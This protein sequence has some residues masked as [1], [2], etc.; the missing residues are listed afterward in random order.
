MEVRARGTRVGAHHDLEG[1]VDQVLGHRL[2]EQVAHA[3]DEDA[4]GLAPAER[5]GQQIGV[6]RDGEAVPVAGIAHRVAL[7]QSRPPV[8]DKP[9]LALFACPQM[10]TSSERTNYRKS[11]DQ[12]LRL[13]QVLDCDVKLIVR[14]KRAW[15][16]ST[17]RVQS[18]PWKAAE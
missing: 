14:A 13:L 6:E 10:E 18:S 1:P 15:P 12:M 4:P 7:T 8:Q 16:T 5:E 11:V 9:K 17:L 3:V 2:V